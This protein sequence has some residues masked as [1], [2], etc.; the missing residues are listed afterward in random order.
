MLRAGDKEWRYCQQAKKKRAR[1]YKGLT[2]KD[3]CE[4]EK[5]PVSKMSC[6]EKIIKVTAWNNGFL[7]I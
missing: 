3:I 5:L 2:F 7:G 4:E 6:I 1:I